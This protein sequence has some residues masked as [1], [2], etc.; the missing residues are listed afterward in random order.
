ML[1]RM[2]LD[3]DL[4]GMDIDEDVFI[5]QPQPE[6]FQTVSYKPKKSSHKQM[7]T[8]VVWPRFLP[9][10]KPIELGEHETSLVELM[11][12]I[13][14]WFESEQILSQPIGKLI[15]CLHNV[16]TSMTPGVITREFSQQQP[17]EMKS[18]Y[19]E[20]QNCCLFTYMPPVS[21]HYQPET[22]MIS[23]F[24]LGLTAEQISNHSSSDV[25]V[26]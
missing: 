22:M 23:T 7:V 1:E 9:Q 14:D 24:P 19:I 20:N 25:K 17:G 3:V 21:G 15:R 11:V 18:I 26:N 2:D 4:N 16:K 12:D 6:P 8:H 13:V 5:N 10:R